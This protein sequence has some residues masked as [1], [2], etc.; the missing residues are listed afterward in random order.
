LKAN[1]RI[2]QNI[3]VFDSYPSEDDRLYRLLEM[4]QQLP[5][6]KKLIFTQTKK[7]A[8]ELCRQLR[9]RNFQSSSI[10]GDKA[11]QERDWALEQFKTG[12]CP[13]LI[14]TDVAAR[15]IDVKDVQCVINFDFPN[16]IEDYIHRIGRTGRGGAD[17]LAFSF[18]TTRGSEDK[19]KMA[20]DLVKILKEANQHVPEELYPLCNNGKSSKSSKGKGK[21]KGNRFGGFGKGMG[22]QSRKY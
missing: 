12:H 14:A 20:S 2:E 17:G 4:V 3:E 5:M 13:I 16:N 22:K 15:G 1:H 11:Q 6:G 18:F 7:G 10:H 9:R 19:T 8:D 21:G